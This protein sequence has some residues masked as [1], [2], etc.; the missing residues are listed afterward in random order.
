MQGFRPLRRHL[1]M[2]IK[3]ESI[4]FNGQWK[5]L[6]HASI[7]LEISLRRAK[8]LKRHCSS[9]DVMHI[10]IKHHSYHKGYSQD[11][12]IVINNFLQQ[13]EFCFPIKETIQQQYGSRGRH[14]CVDVHTF[15]NELHN[16]ILPLM[17]SSHQICEQSM[18]CI[19]F[20]VQSQVKWYILP[21]MA[22]YTY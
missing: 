10:V 19:I 4:Q 21:K 18:A 5:S 20:D 12:L 2:Q 15:A 1:K 7:L 17:F 6:G 8:F 9:V 13:R 14:L 22:F 11:D 16:I 3:E